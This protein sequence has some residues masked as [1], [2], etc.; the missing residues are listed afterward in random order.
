MWLPQ[1]RKKKDLELAPRVKLPIKLDFFIC[2]SV[3][4]SLRRRRRKRK[5]RETDWSNKTAGRTDAGAV[6]CGVTRVS[7]QGS[8]FAFGEFGSFV[9]RRF[10][11]R[12]ALFG[13]NEKG[14]ASPTNR[15]TD[16]ST[17]RRRNASARRK[18]RRRCGLHWRTHAHALRAEAAAAEK[19]IRLHGNFAAVAASR[20]RFLN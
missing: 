8:A 6:R 17:Q 10:G 1:H 7:E 16:G 11:E 9:R 12:G 19:E 15:P 18:R 3:G 5:E 14:K 4:M 20:N 13:R 2:I